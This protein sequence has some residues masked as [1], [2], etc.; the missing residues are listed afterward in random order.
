MLNSAVILAGGKSSRMGEDKALLPFGK[1]SSLTKFQYKRLKTIFKNVYISTKVNKFDFEA[2]LILDSSQYSS[3]MVALSSILNSLNE[4]F[5]LISVDMPLFSLDAI[6]RLI[7]EY[8]KDLSYDLYLYK[9]KK[10]LEPTA[11]I[12]KQSIKSK[13]DEL[14]KQD[15]HKLQFLA[16]SLNCK[17]LSTIDNV[18]FINVNKKEDYELAKNYYFKYY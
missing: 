10:F 11:A 7:S 16:N 14:L 17:I 8:K 18:N 4:D 2:D 9:S 6:N 5:F 3:P 12:Y 15:I 1:E 13:V